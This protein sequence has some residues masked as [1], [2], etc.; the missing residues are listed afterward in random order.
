MPANVS[1]AFAKAQKKYHEARTLDEKFAALREMQRSAP[2]H[3]GGENLRAEISRKMKSLREKMEKREE[4]RKKTAAKGVS[5]KK[6]GIGQIVLVGMPNTGKST[7]LRALTNADVEIADYPFTTKKPEVGMI[8]FENARIQLVEI[9]PLIKGSA[10]GKASGIELLS[11]VRTADA[12]ALVLDSMHPLQ[13]FSL[14]EKELG[15]VKIVIGRE[16]PK[17]RIGPTKFKGI[18]I[19]GKKFFKGSREDLENFLKLRGIFNAS[20]VLRETADEKKLE[21]VLDRSIVYKP[22]LAL[23]VD[24]TGKGFNEEEISGLSERTEVFRVQGI[25]PEEVQRLKESFF[26]LLGKILVFTKKPGS[27]KA[28]KPLALEE[29]ATVADVAKVLHKDIA[30]SFK[31]ARVWGSTRFQGQKVSRD[32]VLKNHDVVEVYS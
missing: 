12:V 23:V 15:E 10:S 3:K 2:S 20:V 24:R 9:P 31:Y 32:Y 7:L 29:G 30:H 4:Q 26:L 11:I 25:G 28:E 27:E 13:Q 22:A 16:K 19:T 1:T 8:D 18:F 17:I 21:E 6:E 14:L 5:V